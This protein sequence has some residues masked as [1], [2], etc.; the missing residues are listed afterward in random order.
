MNWLSRM[1]LRWQVAVGV[2]I[3]F[4]FLFGTIAYVFSGAIQQTT[5]VVKRERLNLA[6]STANSI[7]ALIDHTIDQ[8]GS[9]A[10]LA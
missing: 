5:E 4:T 8:L 6:N 7:D 2:A 9:V 1:G 3:I 10:H